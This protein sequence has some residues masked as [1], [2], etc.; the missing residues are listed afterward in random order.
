MQSVDPKFY[1]KVKIPK[2]LPPLE[3]SQEKVEEYNIAMRSEK[4]PEIHKKIK[5][6]FKFAREKVRKIGN[7]ISDKAIECKASAKEKGGK[8][9]EKGSKWREKAK[10]KI[11]TWRIG[12]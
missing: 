3:A 1:D 12:K 6:A 2:N 11:E 4:S 8:L 9:K 5:R 7:S 10:N